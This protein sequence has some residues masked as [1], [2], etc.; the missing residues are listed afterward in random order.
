[1]QQLEFP[2]IWPAHE[3]SRRAD[4]KMPLSRRRRERYGRTMVYHWSRFGIWVVS[5]W[6]PIWGPSGRVGAA[7]QCF[8]GPF[9]RGGE[10]WRYAHHVSSNA[11]KPFI[12]QTET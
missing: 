9:F 3:L 12:D 10:A 6:A 5:T 2:F 7:T 8:F 11:N 4:K 1:M